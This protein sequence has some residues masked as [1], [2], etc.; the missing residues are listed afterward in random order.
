MAKTNWQY[1][2]VVKETDLNQIGQEINAAASSATS[3]Q[4]SLTTH[5][6]AAVLD[7]PDGSVTTDKLAAKTVTQAKI[8]DKAVGQGQL[9]DKAVGSGQLA[10]GSATDT[11]IGTRTIADGTAATGDSGTITTLLGWIANML[12]SITGKS[13]WR[14]APATSLE[15]AKTHMD[16]TTGVHGATSAATSNAIMQRD[17]SG[18]VQVASPSAAADV[19]RK[20][21]V[22]AAEVN[23]KAYVDINWKQKWPLTSDTGTHVVNIAS[24]EDFLG[25]INPYRTCTFYTNPGVI[26]VPSSASGRGWQIAQANIGHLLWIDTSN[27]AYWG[28]YGPSDTAVKWRMI[29]DAADFDTHLADMVKHVTALERA[30]W[31]AK[32][33]PTGAQAKVN[34]HA[35]ASDPHP[36]YALETVVQMMKITTDTGNFTINASNAG[37][38][39]LAMVAAKVGMNTVY[40]NGNASNTPST[41]SYRGISFMSATGSNP[42]GFVVLIGT[43]GV[44]TNYCNGSSGWYGWRKHQSYTLTS[45]NGFGQVHTNDLNGLLSTGI[46]TIANNVPNIPEAATGVLLVTQRNSTTSIQTWWNAGTTPSMYTRTTIDTGTTWT[47]WRKLAFEDSFYSLTQPNGKPLPYAGDVNMLLDTGIYIVNTSNTNL[48]EAVTSTIFVTRRTNSESFQMWI[49]SATGDTWIRST[50]N[51]GTTWT[52]WRKIV[53]TDMAQMS[54]ITKDDGNNIINLT[55]ATD[56]L[57][58]TVISAGPGLRTIYAAGTVLN[59]PSTASI[60]GISFM[61]GGAP[62]GWILAVDTNNRMYTNSLKDGV[63]WTG[64]REREHTGN[65]NMANGYAGIG[66][67]GLIAAAQL[68]LSTATNSTSTTQAATPSAVK[69]AYDLASAALPRTGGTLTGNTTI[70]NTNPAIVI[71][72]TIDIVGTTG[73]RMRNAAGTDMFMLGHSTLNNKFVLYDYALPGTSIAV[74]AGSSL[75]NGFTYRGNKVYHA[76]NALIY[77]GSGSPIG[78]VSAPIGSIYQRT[79][80][81]TST[82]LYIKESGTGNTGWRSV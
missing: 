13:N 71:Q 65:K 5:K 51:T 27:R 82:T 62:Y 45:Y 18:R 40:C 46:Y 32:E 81:G 47:A 53:T 36:Q 15:A 58:A 12:K 39:L 43:D 60:R 77:L 1:N 69:S 49:K 29:T 61:Q 23:A 74:E 64:W 80:G 67:D 17:A 4:Q 19:A 57:L 8:G 25:R 79:D 6:T 66:A 38:D 44:Y 34:T 50:E 48:P 35:T 31:N 24:G 10:D 16:A 75:A 70:N 41:S 68:P 21:T 33:T 56:D 22:D 2:D 37:D 9:G 11:V 59:M 63:T 26:G 78:V 7:H 30:E 73:M 28:I 55:Q 76:G 3:A 42:F 72:P 14:T 52:Q 54:K 20:D